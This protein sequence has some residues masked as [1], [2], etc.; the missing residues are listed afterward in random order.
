[1]GFRVILAEARIQSPA[2]HVGILE[3]GYPHS[4]VLWILACAG[5]THPARL[6]L[7]VMQLRLPTGQPRKVAHH[8]VQQV[9]LV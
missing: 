2:Y 1:M 5:T 7:G 3:L 9:G 6:R 8:D 4:R